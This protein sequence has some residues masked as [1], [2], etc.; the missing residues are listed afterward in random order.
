MAKSA[1]G[2]AA[3]GAELNDADEV[4]AAP[5]PA[6]AQDPPFWIQWIEQLQAVPRPL[7]IALSAVLVLGVAAYAFWP[8]ETQGVALTQIRQRPEAYEGRSVRVAGKAGDAFA[9]GG[10]YVYNLYQGRDTIV[11]YTRQGPPRLNSRVNVAG[12]VSI[13]YLD[14]VPRVALLESPSTP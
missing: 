5:M 13:G 1:P 4:D 2:S 9:V 10:S 12:T 14:G 8:R 7:V 6:L 3:R 11:V